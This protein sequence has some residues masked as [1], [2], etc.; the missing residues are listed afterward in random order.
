MG[1]AVRLH[2]VGL[3]QLEFCHW[4]FLLEPVDEDKET[5]TRAS[6]LQSAS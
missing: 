3:R 1:M 4:Y 2:E 5:G 6:W